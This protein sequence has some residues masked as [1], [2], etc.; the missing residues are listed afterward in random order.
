MTA[1]PQKGSFWSVIANG[2]FRNLWLGQITSQIALNMLNFALAIRVYEITRSNAAVSTMLLTF[3]IPSIIMGVIAGG[4][5][6]YFDKRAVLIACN[7]FRTVLFLGFF[8]FSDQLIVLY[9]LNVFMSLGTQLFIPAEGPA[10]S[11]V[12]PEHNLLRANS[13]FSVTFFLSTMLGFVFAGPLV[14][15]VGYEPAYLSMGALML[16]AT[17]FTI[18]LPTL[19]QGKISGRFSFSE[20]GWIVRSIRQGMSFIRH[21]RRVRRSLILLTVSQ[22]LIA[23]LAVLAPGFADRILTL[24]LTDASYVVMGPAAAGLILG[25]LAVGH[26]GARY[27]KGTLIHAGIFGT[28]VVLI[29][30]SFPSAVFAPAVLSSHILFISV[31]L[32]FFLGFFNSWISVPANTILQQDSDESM[33]GRIYG[34][35]T[36]LTG[37]VSLLPVLLSGIF[38]DVFGIGR[39]MAGIGIVLL[40]GWSIHYTIRSR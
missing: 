37:G 19:N 23:T 34:V 5:V 7:A 39:T 26:W 4:I 20:F 14:R 13:L 29:L 18:L 38:A 30:L 6:E 10:I 16:I 3:A 33:R 35:L 25:A 21:T 12:V 24:D 8:V 17:Y 2:H 11:H 1:V 40:L 31:V 36:S 15:N 32:L 9:I 28:G 22:V 27:L